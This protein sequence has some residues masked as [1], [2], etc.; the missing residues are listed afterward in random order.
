MGR[1]RGPDGRNRWGPASRAVAGAA[2]ALALGALP[3]A[4]LQARSP[5]G[6]AQGL[7]TGDAIRLEGRDGVRV[8]GW[9]ARIAP[10]TI[11]LGRNERIVSYPVSDLAAVW[12]G[13]RAV[14]TGAWIGA[15]VGGVPALVFAAWLCE[16][17]SEGTGCDEW[18]KVTLFGALGGAAGAGVGALIG[19]F[20]RTWELR[21][22]RGSVESA[23]IPLPGGLGAGVIIRL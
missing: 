22:S 3:A 5:E 15:I 8:E 12:K 16:F 14:G 11:M 13:E 2:I 4:G 7:R 1:E 6:P 17:T 21:W 19:S 9:V 18:A 10:D 20:I 23:L